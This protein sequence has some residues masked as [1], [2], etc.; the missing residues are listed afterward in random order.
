M[1]TNV[2]ITITNSGPDLGP[3][4]LFYGNGIDPLTPGP[5]NI[6]KSVLVAGYTVAVP[7]STVFVRVQSVNPSCS[8]NYLTLT[9]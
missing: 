2:L 8:E 4:N 6:S 5:V 1:A 7:N 9:I 3:Y